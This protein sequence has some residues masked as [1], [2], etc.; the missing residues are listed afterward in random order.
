MSARRRLPGVVAWGLLALAIGWVAYK[1]FG[2]GFG[3][4]SAT[5][6]FMTVS[7]NALSLAGLYFITASGFTLI[8][9]LLR[10]VNMAH[11]ALYLFGGYMTLTFLDDGLSWWLATALGALVTGVLGL[12]LQQ[13]LLRWNQ[14]QELRQA[15]ITIA[16]ATIVGDQLVVRFGSVP[17]TIIPPD[18]LATTVSLGVYDL[19]YPAFRLFLIGAAVAVGIALWALIRHTRFGIAIRAGVDDS[20]MTSA[21]GVNVQLVFAVAF[22]LG[23]MLAGL[24]GAFG[25]SVLSLAPGEDDHFLLSSLVVVIVGGLGSLPGAALGALLL[26]F[27]EQ[28]AATY[29]PDAYTN[30]AILLTFVLLVVVLAVRP[31][32]FFGRPGEP[33]GR[34]T[35][36]PGAGVGR[37]LRRHLPSG[38]LPQLLDPARIW[39]AGRRPRRSLDAA[40]RAASATA[41]RIRPW[42]ARGAIAAVLVLLALVPLVFSD[43]FTGAVA[44]RALWLGL[45]AVSL[46]FLA[47]YAGMVSL[48]Q[49]ALFGVG[50][51]VSAKLIVDSGVDPWTAAIV[52]IVAAVAVGIV[53]GAVASG[54]SGIYFLMIT[55]AFGVIVFFF[56]SQVPAFGGHEGINGVVG[57]AYIGNPVSDPMAIYYTLLLVSVLTY[58]GVRYLGRTPL[59][60]TLQGIR[61][62]PVRMNALGY[63]VR[64]HR[65]L[66]FAVGALIAA[67]AGVLATWHQTRI[68]PG[69]IDITRTIELLVIAVIGG[70]YR[71][72]GAWIGALAFTLLNTYTR[73][74]TGRFETWIGIAFLLIV[75]LS[76]GGIAGLW[77][78][79]RKR[80]RRLLAERAPDRRRPPTP[81]TADRDG[82]T[83]LVD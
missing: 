52:A 73:G 20:A 16:V 22:F 34:S 7:L 75:L 36:R 4:A 53:F 78:A 30:Y 49:T 14:G 56:F 61:D 41:D 70:L 38:R 32:G 67:V 13:A 60:V 27:V 80:G 50:G 57:P 23:A 58:L 71:L 37:A 62:D 69:T 39:A 44:T 45:A 40:L 1:A 51:F 17:Q 15:L 48:S 83:G 31:T 21:V 81:T 59:G 42:G 46:I 10:V 76:P 82:P 79:A 35:G 43:Y 29:L 63:N 54:S 25:G 64:L 12:A 2:E 74:L 19:E 3:R 11:G 68:S 8:F 55:L 66:A 18:F 5:P 33:A 24:G 47:G 9:G 28:Y 77:D 72:E 65:T 26:A 6:T